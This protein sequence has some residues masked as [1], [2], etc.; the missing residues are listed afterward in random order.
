MS[1]SKPTKIFAYSAWDIVPVLAGIV[2]LAFVVGLYFVYPIAPWWLLII[3]GALYA[4]SISWSINSVSHNFLHNPYFTSKMLNRIF[5]LILS[6]AN[7]F[8]QCF[9]TW[10]H[11]RH[12]RGNSD[13]PNEN[14]ETIDWLSI[15]RHGKNG[16]AEHVLSYTFLGF[17]REMFSNEGAELYAKLKKRNPADARFGSFEYGTFI[18]LVLIAAVFNWHAV[19]FMVPWYYLGNCLSSLNGYYRHYG[20][21]PDTPIAWGVSTYAKFYNWLW[22]NNGYHAEHH[23]RPRTHWTKIQE[24]HEQIKEKQAAAGVRV[25]K[26][27]HA[28]GFLEADKGIIHEGS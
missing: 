3:W 5:S 7:G 11:L 15:Y 17:F 25:I 19:L 2:H 27:C 22:F 10:V 23:Y 28:L 9:Y 12:H 13:K 14:G 21:D 1:K 20:A 8:S 16:K 24:L 18:G 6:L 26:N 4:V